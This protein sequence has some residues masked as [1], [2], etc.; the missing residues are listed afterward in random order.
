MKHYNRELNKAIYILENAIYK[1]IFDTLYNYNYND[2][3]SDPKVF[4]DILTEVFIKNTI[5][6]IQSIKKELFTINVEGFDSLQVYFN[7][8]IYLR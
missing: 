5:K 2:E 6:F 8:A 4:V 1:D 7:R 3:N